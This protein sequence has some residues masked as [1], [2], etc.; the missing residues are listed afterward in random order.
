MPSSDEPQ[1]EFARVL[2]RTGEEYA[3]LSICVDG[4]SLMWPISKD[5]VLALIESGAA[6]LRDLK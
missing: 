6:A 5:R 3:T 2:A 4:K 1:I